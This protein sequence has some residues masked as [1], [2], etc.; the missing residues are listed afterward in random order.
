MDLM[1]TEAKGF[2]CKKKKKEDLNEEFA[3]QWI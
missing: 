1:S 3:E 2:K